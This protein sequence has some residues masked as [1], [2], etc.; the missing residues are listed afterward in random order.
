[1]GNTIDQLNEIH[2]Y[3]PIGAFLN[4]YYP[5]TVILVNPFQ[6]KNNED[7]KEIYQELLDK[8]QN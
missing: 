2:K 5:D 1:M 4:R 7:V 8:I 6:I 3:T